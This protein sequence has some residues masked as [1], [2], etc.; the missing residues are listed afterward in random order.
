MKNHWNNRFQ[1]ENYVYCTEPND[2]ISEM[3]KSFNYP[4]MLWLLLKVK[5]E[6]PF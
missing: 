3:K 4:K 1:D 6:M 5:V 2:F